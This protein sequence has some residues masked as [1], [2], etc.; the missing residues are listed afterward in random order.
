MLPA[1]AFTWQV[2]FHH[3]THSHPHMAATSGAQSGSFTIPTTGETSANVWYRIYLTVRDSAGMTHTSTRDIYPRTVQ[4]TL[5]TNP[6]GLQLRLDG[7]PISTP[8]SFQSVVGH[9]SQSRRPRH[10]DGRAARPTSSH[11]G[12]TAA[13]SLTTC[14]RPRRTRRIRRATPSQEAAEAAACPPPISTTAI[15]ADRPCP[16]WIRRSTSRGPAPRSPASAL[17]R[18][19]FAGPDRSCRNSARPTRSTRSATMASVSG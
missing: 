7:Q 9:R 10:A 19:A 4:V 16:G 13:R 18:S 15:S 17:I 12:P 2:D 14:P 5:A 8:L 1:S 11:R 6:A 3:D